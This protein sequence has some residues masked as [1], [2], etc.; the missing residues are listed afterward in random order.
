MSESENHHPRIQSQFQVP[1][2]AGGS[3]IDVICAEIWSDYS[4]ARIAHWI[5][6]GAIRVDGAQVKPKHK[7]FGGEWI[8][9]DAQLETQVSWAG[10]P[11][12]LTPL[13]ADEHLI[14][15]DKPAGLVVHPGH[16][17]PSHTL[18]NALLHHYP[19]LEAIPRAGI[20]HRLDKDTSGVLAIARSLKAHQRL[21]A[22]LKDRSMGRQYW[23][24]VFGQTRPVGTID[25]PMD[26]HRIQRTKMAVMTHGKPA[27]THYRTL[28]QTAHFSVI[29]VRLETG[30]THQ[31]R[32]HMTH[33]GHPLVGDP[34]YKAGR[35]GFGSLRA[36]IRARV[37]AFP[38]QALHAQTLRLVHP[39][40]GEPMEFSAP[41]A[42]DLVALRED[43]ARDD[44]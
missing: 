2:D 38:R 7:V 12:A 31:I 23:A 35:P 18:V 34:V 13:Y 32:V 6:E 21:I 5:T 43:I 8:A 26:R 42:E 20:V 11:I 3:R 36:A 14:V 22:Q 15:V 41:L 44:N 33:L 17:N 30:R 1:L 39:A 10:Q 27:V 4:R 29:E 19:E 28:Q 16:G 37:E 40:T 25:A 9:L 24:L